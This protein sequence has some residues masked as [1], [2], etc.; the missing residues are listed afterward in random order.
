MVTTTFMSS[1]SEGLLRRLM[2]ASRCVEVYRFWSFLG[3]SPDPVLTEALRSESQ[4]YDSSDVF[5][6]C[7]CVF[8]CWSAGNN[9]CAFPNRPCSQAYKPLIADVFAQFMTLPPITASAVRKD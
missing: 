4:E 5:M 8:V 6:K 2:C 7:V 3:A 9:A 1:R